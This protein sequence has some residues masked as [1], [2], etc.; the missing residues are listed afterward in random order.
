MTS[1]DGTF[2]LPKPKTALAQTGE[3][4]TAD[5]GGQTEI[6]H[7]HRY[8]F[9]RDLCA[10]RDVLDIASG[11]G[12]GAALLADVARSVLGVE[13]DSA[14]LVH[15]QNNYLAGNLSFRL[16]S[17]LAIPAETAAFDVVICFETLEHFREHE[18]FLAEVLRV[19]R[20]G[21]ILV[22]STPDRLVYSAPGEP[23]NP[24][25]VRELAETEFR[26]LLEASFSAVQM[27]RQRAMVGSV[28]A[29]QDQ[30]PGAV[31]PA[32]RS[33]ERRQEGAV[34]LIEVSAGMARAPYLIAM[35][36]NTALPALGPSTYAEPLDVDRVCRMWEA[37]PQLM[38]VHAEA[39]S[40]AAHQAESLRSALRDAQAT[41][42][43]AQTAA[44]HQAESLRSALRD[45][46][47]VL[48]SVEPT[49]AQIESAQA[50]TERL[51]QATSQELDETRHHYNTLLE[52]H[53]ATISSESWRITL[54]LRRLGERMPGLAMVTRRMTKLVWWTVTLQLPARL[55]GRNQAPM[56]E[57]ATLSSPIIEPNMSAEQPVPLSQQDLAPAVRAARHEPVDIIICI[58]N[59]LDDVKRCLAS[60]QRTTLP[61]YRL[62][63]VDDGSEEE[64]QAFVNDFIRLHGATLV[65]HNTALGYTIAANAGLREMVA[66]FCVLLNSDAEVTEGWLDRMMDAMRANP[67]LG[68]VGP[69][70]NTAS[71]Q[72]VPKLEEDGDWAENQLHA[73]MVAED[74]ARLLAQ[75]ASPQPIPLGFINGFCML[76]RGSLIA[77][78][79]FFDEENFGRGYG[80]E[81]DF[82]IRSR[83]AG[84]ELAVVEDAYV[85]HYQS[86]SYGHE[87]RKALAAKA[88]EVLIAKHDPA[89]HIMPHAERCRSSLRLRAARG[90]LA[91]NLRVQALVTSAGK[92]FEGKR[93]AFVLPVTAV[94]GGANV[95]HQEALAMRAFGVDAMIVNHAEYSSGYKLGYPDLSLPVRYLHTGQSLTEAIGISV[96]AVLATA[97][98]SFKL[99]HGLKDHRITRAYYIQDMETEFFANDDPRR[100]DALQTYVTGS[101]T[102]RVTKSVWNREM[103]EA[104]GGIRPAVIGP[105]VD[106]HSFG[107]ASDDGLS[108]TGPVRVT[109]M[110][111]PSTPRRNPEVTARVLSA[112]AER[113]G[114]AVRVSCFGA[115]AEELRATGIGLGPVA[116]HGILQQ[117]EI[118]RLLGQTDVFLDFSTWQAMGLT[119]LEAM[120]SGAAVVVPALGGAS[121]FCEHGVSGLVIDTRDEQACYDAAESLVADAAMRLS[122][123]LA[124]IDA[125]HC[126]PPE[127]AAYHLLEEL[128]PA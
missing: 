26:S 32:W 73:G 71:W 43:E 47:S 5:L 29:P 15:A 3:R 116:N 66:P 125:A 92:R 67:R 37:H 40:E 39:Q 14:A 120:A 53:N 105:S 68:V 19:L 4:M 74:M 22:I 112:L 11:E 85:Y 110:I 21:G 96:D 83:M 38:R 117:A 20:P 44:A 9:A 34:N 89:I 48:A 51:V 62:I 77:D 1:T 80:E 13:I 52:V 90:R 121:E 109:A 104:I 69:L 64:T 114:E 99:V 82:C 75:G 94:G 59:A 122:L 78:V 54:P 128:F 88:D 79:G 35:A 70:S 111:R 76:I 119:A 57:A 102:T 25:H 28:L 103:V 81:N 98:S 115:S 50:I 95:I 6:E 63:L 10:G 31:P 49:I 91:A 12:Y 42:A 46:Q 7:Y 33:Y 108:P 61:P 30:L 24:Y 101:E 23:L 65:R 113:H 107:P 127:V 55:R 124:G 56:A 17:A 86:R 72:S 41:A 84:W 87:R 16:G 93:V 27:W 8:A 100:V 36:S 2:Q 18:A 58:H 126:Y 97:Y 106:L 118:A 45:A 60:V 123:R